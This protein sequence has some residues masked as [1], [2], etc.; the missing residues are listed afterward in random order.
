MLAAMLRATCSRVACACSAPDAALELGPLDELEH[1]FASEPCRHA[2]GEPPQR[3]R[4]LG[5]GVEARAD[6]GRPRER[7]LERLRDVVG[8]DVVEHAEA[9]PGQR[10]RLARREPPPHVG[11]EVPGGRDDGPAR[12]A[13]VAGVHDHGGHAAG[14]RLA[15]QQRLGRRL[16]GAVVAVGGARLVLGDRHARG[17]PVDPDRAAVDQQ[18]P[19][20]GAAR[21]PVAVRTR[22]RSRSCRSPRRRRARRSAHRTRRC[23]PRPPDRSRSARRPATRAQGDTARAR[24]D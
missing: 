16:A 18:R 11:I 6:R 4:L 13:D 20:S 10:E 2:G 24:R 7:T 14:D 5:D 3:H 17:R 21:R 19:S 9:E 15:L 1:G 12:A 23:A 22:R 8:V